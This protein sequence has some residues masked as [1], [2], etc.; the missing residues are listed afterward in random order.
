[1]SI[2]DPEEGFEEDTPDEEVRELM[3]DYDLEVEEAEEV[4]DIM[5]EYG[6]DEEEAIEL[7]DLM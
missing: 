6:L 5:E 7:K 4:K 2:P 3:V 1:M